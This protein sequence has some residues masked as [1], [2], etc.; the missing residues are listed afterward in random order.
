MKATCLKKRLK[1]A[2]GLCEKA[3]GK[4]LSLPALSGVMMEAKDGR[5]RLSATNLEIGMEASFPAKVEKEGRAVVPASVFA[6]FLA[7]LP[8]DEKITLETRGGNL[9]VLA[10]NSSTVVKGQPADDFPVLPE[11]KGGRE[12]SVPASEFAGGLRAVSY[13][14]SPL[15]IKPEISSVLVSPSGGE[16]LVF[17]ATDSFRL[18][19][20]R[21]RRSVPELENLLIPLRSVSEIIRVFDGRP[22]DVKIKAD[23]NQVALEAE[24]VKFVSRLTDGV[25][26]DY[27]Q[28]IPAKF[29]ADVI[30]DKAAFTSTLRAAAVFSGK[31]NEVV[32]NVGGADGFMAISSS[33]S[34]AGEHAA[35]L[36]AK[37]TGEE[38]KMSFNHRY[39][40][41]CLPHISSREIILRF[42][43]EGRPLVIAGV[44]D[45]SF[46]YLVMPMNS[47]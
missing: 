47:R 12:A 27:E 17:A 6:G 34:E 13:A 35:S 8:G 46:R 33:G 19:E 28:I 29:V 32:L 7:T 44:D 16:A 5:V 25:F 41:D 15:D 1:D 24:G 40:F 3:T 36:P 26:P 10:P 30:V 31:L 43:G 45:P 42:S 2:V 21:V 38:L 11:V 22:D 39:L 20:K 9:V 4:N 14:A 18:A 23:K 37:T